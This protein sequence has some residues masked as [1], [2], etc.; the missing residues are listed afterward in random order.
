[1]TVSILKMCDIE[2]TVILR[3]G[4]TTKFTNSIS[5][6][7]NNDR[8]AEHEWAKVTESE[9]VLAAKHFVV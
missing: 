1:M 8:N 5:R 3:K 4:K 6:Y 9:Q 2:I 7:L